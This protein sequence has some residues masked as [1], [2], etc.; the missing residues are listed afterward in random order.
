MPRHSSVM[1]QMTG[2]EL[3]LG[4]VTL[5][6]DTGPSILASWG[7]RASKS[8]LSIVESGMVCG[9]SGLGTCLELLVSLSPSL[10]PFPSGEWVLKP[11]WSTG[12]LLLGERRWAGRPRV[13]GL[14]KRNLI[15]TPG[16]RMSRCVLCVSPSR[17][18]PCPSL[19]LWEAHFH[20][21]QRNRCRRSC[22]LAAQSEG[23]V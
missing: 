21:S 19:S 13:V 22:W 17:E 2:L 15:W 18:A 10:W 16:A 4:S 20:N 14:R 9:P 1:V 3:K 7:H 12:F 5:I 23:R 6:S 11:G 8:G